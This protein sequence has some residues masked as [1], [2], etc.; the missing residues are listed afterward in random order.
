MSQQPKVTRRRLV[1]LGGVATVFLASACAGAAG[2]A[3]S[4]QG[5]L[6]ESVTIDFQHRWEGVREPLVA[7]QV[8]DFAALQPNLRINN[9]NVYCSGTEG[10]TGGMPYDKVYAQIAAGTPPDIFMVFSDAA[11]DFSSKGALRSVSDLARRDK[12]DLPKT[13]YPA[14]VQMAT[15]KGSVNGLPQLSAGDRPYLFLS[16]EVLDGAGM[17]PT[18]PPASWEDLIA[19]AQKLSTRGTGGGGFDRIGLDVAGDGFLRFQDWVAR[20]NGKILSDDATKVLFNSQEG[21]DTLQWMFTQMTQLFGNWDNRQAFYQSVASSAPA[22]ARVAYYTNKVGMWP[23]GVWHFFEIKGEAQTYNPQFQYG[24]GLIP[25]NTKN[26]QAKPASLADAV[27]L[28]SIPSGSKK[29]EAAWEWMKYI[30]MGE[31]NR[32]FVKAQNRPSPAIKINE[33][34]DFS[35]DNPHWNTVVKRALEIMVPLPQTRA[36]TKIA[37]VLAKMSTDVMTGARAP[38]EALAD[39][40]REAQTLLDEAQR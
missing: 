26:P 38:R 6:K 40:A 14:L 25:M 32:L 31:G 4:G 27:W 16:R 28:Y 23:N 13:F 35:K 29:A 12:V 1:E 34:P 24:V 17:D 22:G 30:T 37:P 15:Y 9:Q 36:W 10:C 18:K 7:K 3:S 21:Q 5:Q 8:Q 20:N 11:S 19:S 2:S 33:D 39:A